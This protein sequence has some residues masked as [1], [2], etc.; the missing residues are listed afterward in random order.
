MLAVD[1]AVTL[2]AIVVCGSQASGTYIRG[3]DGPYGING[4]PPVV[5]LMPWQSL[6]GHYTQIWSPVPH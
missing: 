6:V 4:A 2:A 3:V 5:V 1:G